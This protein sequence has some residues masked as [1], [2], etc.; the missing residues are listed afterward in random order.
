VALEARVA[1]RDAMLPLL[2]EGWIV[3]DVD[4]VARTYTLSR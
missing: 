4:R 3:T 2:A 1:L